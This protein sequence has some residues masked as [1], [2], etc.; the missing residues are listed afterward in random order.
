MA[1]HRTE[2]GTIESIQNKKFLRDVMN[3]LT[4]PQK[5]LQSKYFYDAAGDK[6][7]QRIM[8][9]DEY[10][11]TRSE[12]EIFTQQTTALANTFIQQHSSFDIIELGAGDA[13]KSIHLLK[14]LHQQRANFT[15]YPVD[16]S[17][18]VIQQLET[19]IPEMLDGINIH[20]LNGEYMEMIRRC[21]E[22]SKQPKVVLFL[23]SSIGN[24]T[25]D[26]AQRFLN[27]ISSCLQPKDLLLV[28]FDLK[29]DPRQILAAYDDKEKITKAFNLNLLR[30]INRELNA[31]F[32]VSCFE[33][34][35]T[36]N[37]VTGATKSYLISL[38]Q[39]QVNIADTII[40]FDKYEPVDMELSQKYSVKE[41]SALTAHLPLQQ[42]QIFYDTHT[43][44][45]DIVWKRL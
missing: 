35:A 23:G 36:Y 3:G 8:H 29:K 26:N 41:I 13:T 42:L 21:Y 33:H 9:C 2:T 4:S 27:D 38:Q 22:M 17:D 40:S 45:A 10:Y 1:I 39:Q 14:E 18:N 43:W 5:Y 24:F 7:F 15:Y 16:I 6:L 37:P 11:L 25:N 28:G 32:D 34:Y 20:G 44:F 31:D 19:T 12:M 30:R